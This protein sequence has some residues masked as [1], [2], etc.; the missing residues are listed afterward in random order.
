MAMMDVY[1]FSNIHAR[2]DFP[3]SYFMNHPLYE[4][5]VAIME[6]SDFS[7]TEEEKKKCGSGE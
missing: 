6:E 2:M 7:F 1:I 5:A 4:E 3:I